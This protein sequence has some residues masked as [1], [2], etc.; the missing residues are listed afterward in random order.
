MAVKR[1][2]LT[3]GSDGDPLDDGRVRLERIESAT[4]PSSAS[5]G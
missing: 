4:A 5:G 1:P 2:P 3:P